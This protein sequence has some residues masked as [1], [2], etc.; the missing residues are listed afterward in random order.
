VPCF[1]RPP[2]LRSL[3]ADAIKPRK[4]GGTHG[5]QGSSLTPRAK[6]A[7]AA[8]GCRR[9]HA[10]SRRGGQ[11]IAQG[12]WDDRCQFVLLTRKTTSTSPPIVVK[13]VA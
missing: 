10:K 6:H 2:M 8:S 7:F 12:N 13:C 5:I 1:R 11:L 4:Q 9:R 3:S